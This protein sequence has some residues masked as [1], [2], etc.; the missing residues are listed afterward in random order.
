MQHQSK[1]HKEWQARP[2]MYAGTLMRS[3]LEASF[4][5]DMDK[6]RWNWE[7]EP[8]CFAGANG[9][10][11]PDFRIL[12]D[13]RPGSGFY[14]E[15]K[16]TV[17]LAW[18]ARTRMLPI[19][20]TYSEAAL[21]VVAPSTQGSY[22]LKFGCVAILKGNNRWER[23]GG[24]WPNLPTRI[25]GPCHCGNQWLDPEF[26]RCEHCWKFNCFG[27]GEP[28][29]PSDP[30]GY[31]CGRCSAPIPCPTCIDDSCEFRAWDPPEFPGPNHCE[32]CWKLIAAT[33]RERSTY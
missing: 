19:R 22:G 11:L 12:F 16:P 2:T 7:Y 15:V 30:D 23:L 28:L 29:P 17:E 9:Q 5:Q 6:R 20:D 1:Q 27:C 31:S 26:G 14:V 32:S 33:Q 13:D 3:R 25:P 24:Y 4:A 8:I 18:D 21:I 10:Y